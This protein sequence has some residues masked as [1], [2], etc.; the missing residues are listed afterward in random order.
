MKL[1]IFVLAAVCS[2]QEAVAEADAAAAAAPVAAE[3][4]ADEAGGIGRSGADFGDRGKGNKKGNQWASSNNNNK[5]GNK[6]NQGGGS[7]PW[8]DSNDNHHYDDHDHYDGGHGPYDGHHDGGEYG[9]Y[10]PPSNPGYPPS[11]PGYGEDPGYGG[12]YDGGHGY[13]D[14][15][16]GGGY[17]TTTEYY[18]EDPTPLPPNST[19]T[20]FHCDAPNFEE[21]Y[22]IGKS[23]ECLVNEG[24]PPV[25]MIEVRKRDGKMFGVCM[26]C[27]AYDACLEQKKSNFNRKPYQC[28][29]RA[30]YGPSVCRQCCNDDNC[31]NYFNPPDRKG[32]EEDLITPSN[33]YY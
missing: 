12:G 29:P 14:D 6:K 33:G 5:G 18:P 1:S 3:A 11:N 19:V 32:W 9:G 31:T 20:C 10:E 17:D 8:A 2:A 22:K 13:G 26:G 7:N 27:K 16:Y 21:C 30:R 15:G 24:R 25:C 4:V 23:M 28:R